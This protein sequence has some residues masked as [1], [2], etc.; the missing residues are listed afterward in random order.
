MVSAKSGNKEIVKHL[1]DA[2]APPQCLCVCSGDAI[3]LTVGHKGE[4]FSCVG[5]LRARRREVGGK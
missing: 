2:G 5:F 1:L 3:T 4:V